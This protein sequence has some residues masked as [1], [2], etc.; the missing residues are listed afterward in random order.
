MNAYAEAGPW[1]YGGGPQNAN[2]CDTDRYLR[3]V[4]M[5]NYGA[6]SVILYRG[7]DLN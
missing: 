7:G 6:P 3:Y 1:D 2:V 5:G 4:Y